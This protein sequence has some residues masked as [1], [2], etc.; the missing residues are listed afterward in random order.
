MVFTDGYDTSSASDLT[1]LR[2]VA[3]RSEAVLHLVLTDTAP[4]DASRGVWSTFRPSDPKDL[5][6][7]VEGTGGQVHTS[8]WRRTSVDRFQAIFDAFR[9]SYLLA[10]SPTRPGAVGWHEISV[11]VKGGCRCEIQTRKGYVRN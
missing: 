11:K 6:R 9:Q 5:Q 2:G 10:F 3:Q 4:G 8:V 1:L 7:I